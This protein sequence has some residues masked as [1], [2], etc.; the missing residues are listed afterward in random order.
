M[1]NL[2]ELNKYRDRNAEARAYGRDFCDDDRSWVGIFRVPVV[3]STGGYPKMLV[4]VS[5]YVE[6]NQKLDA[7]YPWNHVSASLPN[8]CPTWE[9]MCKLKDLFFEPH[10]VAMQLHPAQSD[11]IS[12]HSYCLHIWEPVNDIIPMP[13]SAMVGDKRL[14]TLPHRRT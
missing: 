1:K 12:N 11:N 10:E 9:D 13:P 14:G 2:N 6:G 4:I 3:Q 7:N 5:R 8:K